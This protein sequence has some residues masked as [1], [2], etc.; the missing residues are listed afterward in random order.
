MLFISLLVFCSQLLVQVRGHGAVVFPPPRNNIDHGEAP[1]DA[2]VPF[3]VP[4]VSDPRNGIWCPIPNPFF[5]NTLTGS[6]SV[7]GGSIIHIHIHTLGHNG[8]A[9]FWFSNGCS[10]GCPECDGTTRGPGVHN[11]KND[12][13]ICGL[14][15]KATVC[16]PGLRTVNTGAEC[17]SEADS[18]YF[19][20]WRAPGSA[21]VLDACGMA[22]GAPSWGHHGAQYRASTHAKQ[23]DRAS[24]SL[25]QGVSGECGQS[26]GDILHLS[27]EL[28]PGRL[29]PRS[30]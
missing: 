28:T 7:E 15:H 30:M 9:C 10:I 14:G 12:S 23:G 29:G 16:E 17:G 5:N 25:P 24:L 27:Q 11:H 3:P 1:W 21:P 20:P 18:Y 19:T 26:E 8:Q 22:G 4:A 6:E 2:E 13:D